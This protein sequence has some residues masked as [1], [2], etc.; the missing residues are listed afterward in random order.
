MGRC[1]APFYRE[2]QAMPDFEKKLKWAAESQELEPDDELT[3]LLSGSGE[4]E[5]DEDDLDLVAAA[6]RADLDR[7]WERINRKE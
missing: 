3:R 6:G 4:G 7:F 2:E 1:P 5:L